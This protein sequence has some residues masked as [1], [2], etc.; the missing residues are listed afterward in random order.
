MPRWAVGV[1]MLVS[2]CTCIREAGLRGGV[3]PK[4]VWYLDTVLG[5][6]V[7]FC[8]TWAQVVWDRWAG[9]PWMP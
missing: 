7:G 5:E 4:S 2:G 6:R 9:L 3:G 1:G 8:G